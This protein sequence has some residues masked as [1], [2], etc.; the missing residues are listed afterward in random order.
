MHRARQ[1]VGAALRGLVRVL[2]P[3][4]E[5]AMDL[6]ASQMP[7][8]DQRVFADP[9]IRRM[10]LEDI[11]LGARRNMQALC[12]DV[13]MFGRPW[14]FA[15]GDI[16]VPVHLFYGDADVIVPVHHGEHLA[17]RIPNATLRIR[18]DEGHL[19]GLGASREMFEALLAHWP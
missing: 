12:L 1:P 6:F 3:L 5:Q 13:I 10:F 17:A 19:G 18:P 15:L 4:E 9:A 7:P 2:G 11:Q 16:Q 14:G 8:G